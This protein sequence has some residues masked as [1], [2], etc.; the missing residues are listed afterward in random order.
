[1]ED[2]APDIP[3]GASLK[4]GLTVQVRIGAVVMLYTGLAV[5]IWMVQE[6]HS[7][8]TWELPAIACVPKVIA[9]PTE[10][11]FLASGPPS[12]SHTFHNHASKCKLVHMQAGSSPA[13]SQGS[14]CPQCL[15]IDSSFDLVFLNS[16]FFKQQQHRCR[17]QQAIS[18]CLYPS[19]TR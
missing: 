9:M 2:N 15:A 10:L 3:D 8:S 7:Q 4:G 17:K 11:F 13:C 18:T 16:T 6:R 5:P 14:S 19:R 12:S 1:M